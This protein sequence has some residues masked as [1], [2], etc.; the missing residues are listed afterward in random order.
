MRPIIPITVPTISAVVKLLPF[1]EVE[2]PGA[3]LEGGELEVG[4]FDEVEDIPKAEETVSEIITGIEDGDGDDDED[5][6]LVVVA[7][8][9]LPVCCAA[10]KQ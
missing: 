9:G 5:I 1:D 8:I 2:E 10:P 3:V 4:D 7:V 6:E